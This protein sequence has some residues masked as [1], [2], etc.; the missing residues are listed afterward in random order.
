MS[1]KECRPPKSSLVSNHSVSIPLFTRDFEQPVG[2]KHFVL[3]KFDSRAESEESESDSSSST[4]SGGLSDIAGDPVDSSSKSTSRFPSVLSSR[5]SGS[6]DR[7]RRASPLLTCGVSK[8]HPPIYTYLVQI[9]IL[10]NHAVGKDT[11]VRGIKIFGP[12]TVESREKAKRDAKKNR[13]SRR[14]TGS[15]AIRL[16]EEKKLKRKKHA[17]DTLVSWLQQDGAD[18]DG[19]EHDSSSGEEQQGRGIVDVNTRRGLQIPTSR[20]LDL[21]STLR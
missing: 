7:Q 6:K 18:M 12:P 4:K 14:I 5:P 1:S 13:E 9:C 19:D 21:L 10:A 15:R 16:N 8:K 20:T 3:D 17:K 2:W 11:H